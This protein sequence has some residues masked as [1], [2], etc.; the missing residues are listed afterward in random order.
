MNWKP[1]LK[2][3]LKKI[4]LTIII[5]FVILPAIYYMFIAPHDIAGYGGLFFFYSFLVPILFL[6]LSTENIIIISIVG[7]LLPIL[8]IL[9][10]YVI[11]C[12][13]TAIFYKI[14]KVKIPKVAKP[15][16][17]LPKIKVNIY[18]LLILGIIL[19]GVFLFMSSGIFKKYLATVINDEIDN[20]NR[21]CETHSDCANR[22]VILTCPFGCS[23][24][25]N[26]DVDVTLVD[27]YIKLH[28]RTCN[29]MC[30]YVD[31]RCINNTCVGIVPNW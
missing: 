23:L 6:A 19:L 31:C 3:D 11:A 24:C 13:L 18:H 26:K 8:I 30:V 7:F 12:V 14:K 1:F 4:I 27:T 29:Y 5:F 21:S 22:G 15:K 20:L 25:I 28:G 2:P 9:F 17:K 10:W 16:I